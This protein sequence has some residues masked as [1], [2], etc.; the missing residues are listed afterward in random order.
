M[1]II[2]ERRGMPDKCSWLESTW[3]GNGLR[4]AIAAGS[5]PEG[6][7]AVPKGWTLKSK[8]MH[9]RG[10]ERGDVWA[11]MLFIRTDG[12]HDIYLNRRTGRE[13]W[14]TAGTRGEH[15]PFN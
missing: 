8:E 2:D 3:R 14:V 4:V 11:R 1:A 15:R 12:E 9:G 6:V 13:I 7:I 5:D 10:Q